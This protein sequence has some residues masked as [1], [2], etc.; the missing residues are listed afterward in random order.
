VI[1]CVNELYLDRSF[2]GREIDADFIRDLPPNVDPCGENGEYHSFVY[3]GPIFIKPVKFRRGLVVQKTYMPENDDKIKSE[4][5][6][7]VPETYFSFCDLI[8]G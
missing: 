7:R 1:V 3:D 2:A 6:D 5:Y 4:G 8:P